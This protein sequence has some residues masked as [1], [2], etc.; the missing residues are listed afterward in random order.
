MQ[1]HQTNVGVNKKAEK[2]ATMRVQ[3]DDGTF[4]NV[5]VEPPL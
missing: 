3:R 5:K 1:Q 2:H 4:H